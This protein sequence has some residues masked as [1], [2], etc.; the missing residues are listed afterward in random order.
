MNEAALTLQ[1]IPVHFIFKKSIIIYNYS[2]FIFRMDILIYQPI[3]FFLKTIIMY[4]IFLKILILI[5]FFVED[6]SETYV[7]KFLHLS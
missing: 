3:H 5:L 7:L 6:G 4:N 2:H 1:F